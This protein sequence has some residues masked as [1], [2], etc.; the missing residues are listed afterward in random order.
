MKKEQKIILA[1]SVIAIIAVM[2]IAIAVI[3]NNNKKPGETKEVVSNTTEN[4]DAVKGDSFDSLQGELVED[5]E[6]KKQIEE[7]FSK[8][9]ALERYSNSSIGPMPGILAEL[10]LVDKDE[11]FKFVD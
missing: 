8:Y 5:E 6:V 3:V 1:I 10:G 7:T 2:A 4:A 9:L 11:L